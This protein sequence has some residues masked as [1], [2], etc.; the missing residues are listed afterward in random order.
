MYLTDSEYLTP[1]TCETIARYC[2]NLEKFFFS[3]NF[4]THDTKAWVNLLGINLQHIEFS[5]TVQGQLATYLMLD[6]ANERYEFLSDSDD[7][8]Q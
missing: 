8:D 1:G 4:H 2:Y 6:I 5:P 7:E 3:L